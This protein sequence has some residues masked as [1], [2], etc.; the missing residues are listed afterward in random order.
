MQFFDSLP[1][2]F[3]YDWC[4]GIA[5]PGKV[6]SCCRAN[7]VFVNV[8][9]PPS[10][11]GGS[12]HVLIDL[13]IL[14]TTDIHA[15]VLPYDYYRDAP[16]GNL[17][18][19]QVARV[20]ARTR[21]ECRNCLL[22]DN[23]DFLH[24]SPLGDL[25]AAQGLQTGRQHPV[26]AA[27]NEIGYDA[28]TLGNHEFNH[29]HVLLAAF[30]NDAQFPV[31]GANTV[32]RRGADPR[33]DS[34]FMPPFALLERMVTDRAGNPHR[35][36]IG[37]LG[38]VTP[39]VAI[40]DRDVLN[41]EIE[42]RDSVEAALAWVPHLR[43]IGADLVVLLSHFGVGGA[44]WV[45]GMEDAAIPVARLSGA[46]VQILGHSHLCFPS[47]DFDPSE[48][49]DPAAGRIGT[50][51]SVMAGAF[52]SHVGRIDLVLAHGSDG[53]RI[54]A[55]RS[56][57][58]DTDDRIPAGVCGVPMPAVVHDTHRKT[59]RTIRQPVGV[60]A[61]P[62]DSFFAL[63]APDPSLALVADAQ[64]NYV[65]EALSGTPWA[66]L[67]VLSAASPF[68]S[69]GRGGE[70]NFVDIPAGE[71]CLRHIAELYSFPNAIRALCLDGET[72][73]EW[74]E[75]SAAVFRRIPPRARDAAL[76]DPQMPGYNFDVVHGLTYTIDL[77]EPSRYSPRGRLVDPRARRVC[78]VRHDGQPI[79]PGQRFILATNSYRSAGGGCFPGVDTMTEVLRR[80]L[81]IRDLLAAHVAR[82]S[83]VTP[84]REQ[85]W[86]FRRMPGT[87]AVFDG[88]PAAVRRL[89]GPLPSDGTSIE[90]VG[91]SADGF[92]RFR[93]HL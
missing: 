37:V 53:F 6:G 8:S 58:I 73:R 65:S 15:H 62:I 13:C 25:I 54:A 33:A 22:F 91:P 36:R 46:D 47:T 75:R 77:A 34:P 44:E 45:P 90:A 67:P 2:A 24:G 55:S 51:P 20:V 42:T 38:L 63:V 70:G 12:S 85:V 35:L 41:G 14:A 89:H 7:G 9:D 27:M 88:S 26:I 57:V 83:P 28:A 31:V 59:L 78:D 21:A 86:Q 80:P 64:R 43:A 68:R 66:D 79:S 72:V 1:F 56:S 82:T 40:W 17:G 10:G 32:R 74:L 30:C 4:D 29:G 76:I 93:L 49:V 52:G 61:G 11:R 16:A 39:Q 84:R 5:V 50:L 19:A 92:H 81:L 60:S 87:T 23:G 71:L 18:L 48:H 3:R 69:G